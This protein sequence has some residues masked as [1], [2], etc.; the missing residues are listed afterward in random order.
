M[1][2][3]E[4]AARQVQEAF[5]SDSPGWRTQAQE[6]A[7]AALRQALEQAETAQG[8]EPKREP[9]TDEQVEKIVKANMSL[10]INLAGIR[11]DF[12]A[13]HGITGKTK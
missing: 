8:Q 2:D 10:Q 13:A 1:T 3:L 11:Q 4:K 5:E 6:K 7:L 9:L 12:E